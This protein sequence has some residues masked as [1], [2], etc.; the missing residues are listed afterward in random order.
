MAD[1]AGFKMANLAYLTSTIQ[2]DYTELMLPGLNYSPQQ[3][4]WISGA[5]GMCTQ[6]GP[7]KY[8]MH[9]H[10]HMPGELRINGALSDNKQF[11]YD[12]K[13]NRGSKM[14]PIKK[15]EVVRR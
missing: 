10:L 12:F 8:D 9:P 6:K 2:D 4:F 1:I 15:C 13:C 7:E 14:N 5:I 3:M 11:A